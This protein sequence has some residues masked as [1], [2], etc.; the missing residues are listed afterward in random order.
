MQRK[1]TPQRTI[2]SIRLAFLVCLAALSCHACTVFLLTDSEKTMF[3]NNEDFSNP[4]T[5]I[6]FVPGGSNFF[7]C[8]YVGFDDG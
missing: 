7:G 4:A 3:F 1:L 8:A 5:R 2:H 6:W